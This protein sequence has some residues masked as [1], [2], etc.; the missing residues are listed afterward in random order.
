MGVEEQSLSH[1]QAVH[2]P[3]LTPRSVTPA[4]LHLHMVEVSIYLSPPPP[5]PPTLSAPSHTLATP[6]H[7]VTRYL[8]NHLLS[9]TSSSPITASSS[10]ATTTWLRRR[11]V[12][13]LLEHQTLSGIFSDGHFA[14]AWSGRVTV[15]WRVDA[16]LPSTSHLWEC[17]T[18]QGVELIHFRVRHSVVHSRVHSS[19]H[20][21][22]SFSE[23]GLHTQS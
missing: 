8:S 9:A 5:L 16:P 2:A 23:E 17:L 1:S 3:S 21:L 7:Q 18:R 4:A 19:L 6:P 15:M 10:P 22:P 12:E 20:L 14:I 11:A 13:F